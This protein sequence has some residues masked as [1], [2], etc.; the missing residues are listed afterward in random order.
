MDEKAKIQAECQEIQAQI[1]TK[2]ENATKEE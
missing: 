1:K 2:K